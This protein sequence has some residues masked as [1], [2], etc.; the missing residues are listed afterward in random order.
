MPDIP[1]GEK[2]SQGKQAAVKSLKQL[3]TKTQV[4]AKLKGDVYGLT[5]AQCRKVKRRS[6]SSDLKP[7]ERRP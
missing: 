3:F 6:E 7:G 4:Y 5:P 2:R 1:E